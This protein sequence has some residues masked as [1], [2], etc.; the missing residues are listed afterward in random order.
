VGPGETFE[1]RVLL[2]V[3][4]PGK[5]ESDIEVYLKEVGIRTVVLHVSGTVIER[6]HESK[7]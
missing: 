2:K 7:P 6:T 5:F 3:G 4:R 1:Y